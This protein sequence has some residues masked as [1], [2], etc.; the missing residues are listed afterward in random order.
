MK[1]VAVTIQKF[2][3]FVEPQRIEIESDVTALVGKNESGKTTILKALHRLHPANGDSRKFELVTEY[4][5]WRLARDR[6]ADPN[7]QNTRPVSAEF[8]VEQSDIDAL[9]G[10]LPGPLLLDTKVFAAKSYANQFYVWLEADLAE[11]IQAAGADASIAAQEIDELLGEETLDAAIAKSKELAKALKEREPTRAKAVGGFAG[12]ADKYRYQVE[13]A[14]LEQ[15]QLDAFAAR[16]PTFFYFS[17]YSVLPGETDLTEL[18]ATVGAGTALSEENQTVVS[19]LAH[20]GVQPK[21]FLDSNYDSRKAELQAAASDLSREVFNYWKVNTDLAVIFG[22]DNVAVANPSTGGTDN[23]RILKIELRDA[24]HGDVETNFSTRS[25]GFQWFFSFFAAFSEYQHTSKPVVVLLDEPGTSLHGEA[26]KDFVDYIFNELGASKQTI[27]TTHSQFMIDPE[28]Y[29]KLRAVHDKATREDN[30]GG[31]AVTHVSLS[32]DRDTI[33]PVESALGYTI[34]QHLFLGSGPHLAVEGSSDF[35]YLM[36]LSSYMEQNGKTPLSPRLAI[37]PVGG[38]SNMPAFVALMGR[39]L[40]VSALVDGSKTA[41]TLD[42]ARKAAE[43][44]GVDPTTIVAVS[45]IDT[46]LPA[47]ADIEDLFA[48]VDYLKLYNW[49]FSRNVQESDLPATPVPI[50]KKLIDLHGWFDHALP[51]HALTYNQPEFFSTISPDT[52][53]RFEKAF[54]KLNEAIA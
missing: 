9:D 53:E 34:S 12:S 47:T 27:Y 24:R 20:A 37:I 29:E 32:A 15:D 51:A 8:A 4:P 11:V 39:R 38:I 22:D 25:T 26:Q 10:V 54:V 52:V 14:V 6:R 31:V 21:D 28:V 33:L 18:A 5:R 41:A 46:A 40:K 7:L 36:R 49:A 35:I 2:R 44:N 42:R 3:N 45:E 19:L 17:N 30:E 13:P 1:L 50:I 43:E 48:P 16:V 23:H